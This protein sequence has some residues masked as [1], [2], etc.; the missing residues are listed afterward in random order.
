[1]EEQESLMK[2]IRSILPAH[3]SES[4]SHCI[5]KG[6]NLIIYAHS[7]GMA[8]QIRFYSVLLAKEFGRTANEKIEAVEIRHTRIQVEKDR[9]DFIAPSRSTNSTRSRTV[10]SAIAA[11]KQALTEDDRPNEK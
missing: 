2:L 8:S 9:S 3:L 6:G 5:R 4:C 1:M 7:A 11:I 10:P